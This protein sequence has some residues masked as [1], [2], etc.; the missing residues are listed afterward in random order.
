MIWVQ[1]GKVFF[2]S[3]KGYSLKSH[4]GGEVTGHPKN[5]TITCPGH[6]LGR[7]AKNLAQ[8]LLKQSHL[9]PSILS[10]S[11]A[12]SNFIPFSASFDWLALERLPV[13][14][15]TPKQ[16]TSGILNML[17]LHRWQDSPDA[18]WHSPTSVCSKGEVSWLPCQDSSYLP[19]KFIPMSL[20][21]LGSSCLELDK[22]PMAKFSQSSSHL[23]V[24]NLCKLETILHNRGLEVARG[25][26]RVL[27]SLHFTE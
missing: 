7:E 12:L 25:Y 23:W 26:R 24:Y 17:L 13:L 16:S 3:W 9:T 19:M 10:R 21:R 20:V 1:D 15:H 4:V 8:G 22:L 18:N 6:G 11:S 14:C 27:Q 5:E 2:V